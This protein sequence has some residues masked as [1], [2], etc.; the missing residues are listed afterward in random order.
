[1]R[2]DR[3]PRWWSN[4]WLRAGLLHPGLFV[5]PWVGLCLL[6]A[7]RSGSDSGDV[8][9]GFSVI[10]LSAF[11]SFVATFVMAVRRPLPTTERVLL[12]L[13]GLVVGGVALV[14]GFL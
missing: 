2:T 14:L 1:M 7:N 12:V 4:V 9:W 13:L 3:R 10:P 6:L 8:A 11:G 5:A